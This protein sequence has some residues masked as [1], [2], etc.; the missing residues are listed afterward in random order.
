MFFVGTHL[1]V[2]K[3]YCILVFLTCAAISQLKNEKEDP[4]PHETVR[5]NPK[6]KETKKS[7]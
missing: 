3:V 7:R 4:K 5:K 6:E 2:V 1:G